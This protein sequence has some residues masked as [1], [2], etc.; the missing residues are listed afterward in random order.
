MGILMLLIPTFAFS[1]PETTKKPSAK[2]AHGDCDV[3]KC[4]K[5]TVCEGIKCDGPDKKPCKIY[6]EGKIPVDAEGK[7]PSQKC[8]PP[9]PDKGIVY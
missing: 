1:E 2:I 9:F 6:E 8:K 7:L 5:P 4:G 3:R